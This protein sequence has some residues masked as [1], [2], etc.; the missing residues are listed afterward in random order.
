MDG[1]GAHPAAAFKLHSMHILH[2]R[3]SRIGQPLEGIQA[4]VARTCLS[5]PGGRRLSIL[6]ID[7]SY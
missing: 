4:C 1:R 7:S 3:M 6:L 2:V 5:Q